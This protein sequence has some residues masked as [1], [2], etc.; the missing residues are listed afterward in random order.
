MTQMP[1]NIYIYIYIYIYKIMFSVYL[2]LKQDCLDKRI[3][4]KKTKEKNIIT[5]VGEK[6]IIFFMIARG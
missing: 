2:N 1:I 5:W 6:T 4:E 3:H